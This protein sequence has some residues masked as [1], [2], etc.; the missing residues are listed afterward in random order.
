MGTAAVARIVHQNFPV[1]WA[2][3]TNGAAESVIPSI[4]RIV[5]DVAPGLPIIRFGTMGELID[6]SLATQRFLQLRYCRLGLSLGGQHRAQV[7]VTLRLVWL[8][9]DDHA[10]RRRRLVQATGAGVELAEMRISL[11]KSRC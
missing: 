4:Q 1:T 2:V 8:Q 6:R 9:P 5:R 10:I 7:V 11:G 3:R